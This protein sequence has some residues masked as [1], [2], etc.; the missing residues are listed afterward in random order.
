LGDEPG[1]RGWSIKQFFSVAG[2]AVSGKLPIGIPVRSPSAG[3]G[4]PFQKMGLNGASL[5]C[6]AR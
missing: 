1:R 2:D 4:L 3:D 6:Q 5:V